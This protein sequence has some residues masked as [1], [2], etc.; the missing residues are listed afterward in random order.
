M[1][2]HAWLVNSKPMGISYPAYKYKDVEPE[3]RARLQA[4]MERARA[5]AA[6]SR[7]RSPS[8]P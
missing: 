6:V 7:A 3:L 4:R 2:S 8:S 1:L 5:L